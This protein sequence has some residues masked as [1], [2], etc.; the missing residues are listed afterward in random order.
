MHVADL[1]AVVVKV[2]G[3]VLGHAL[4]QH[5]DEAAEAAGRGVADLAQHV[6]D[7]RAGRADLDG[8]VDEARR[9]DHLLDEDALGALDLPRA[10]RRRDMHGLRPHGV[11]FLEAQRAIVEAG[12]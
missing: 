10:G 1:H 12:G 7:L 11:P 9:A 2:L 6:V 5:G 4:G 8:R 3:Q